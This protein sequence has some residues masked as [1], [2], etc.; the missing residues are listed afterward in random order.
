MRYNNIGKNK[1]NG[2][3]YTPTEMAD[4]VAKE[5]IKYKK[6][7]CLDCIEI[8]DPAVGK[9]ELMVSMIN[10]VSNMGLPIKAVGYETDK[11]TAENTQKNFCKMCKK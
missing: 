8:L 1:E 7:P 9:G 2:I 6:T 5:M 4:Y 10:A 3:V 11:Y